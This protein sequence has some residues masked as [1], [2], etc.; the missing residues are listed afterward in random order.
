[1]QCISY[2]WSRRA[3]DGEREGPHKHGGEFDHTYFGERRS[4]NGRGHG[5]NGQDCERQLHLVSKALDW[6]VVCG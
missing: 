5:E 2:A 6:M 1:M 4:E 3:E